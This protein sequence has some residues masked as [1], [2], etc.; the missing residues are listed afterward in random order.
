MRV[1]IFSDSHGDR[2][3]LDAL[4]EKMGHIDALGISRRTPPIFEKNW[5]KCRISPF[6]M[7]C[8]A[9]MIWRPC[10]LTVC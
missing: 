4:I 9:T 10:C 1:G 7:P 5:L 8:G 3:A 6:F 2:N